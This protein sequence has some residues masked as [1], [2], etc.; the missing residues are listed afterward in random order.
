MRINL[1]TAKG[2]GFWVRIRPGVPP[3]WQ[4]DRQTAVEHVK[5][6]W[7]YCQP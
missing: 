7:I 5:A 3:I 2:G 6:L 1:W 4:P